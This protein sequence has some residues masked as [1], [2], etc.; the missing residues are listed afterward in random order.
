M[1]STST[2]Q[3]LIAAFYNCPCDSV[4]ACWNPNVPIR[5]GLK[6]GSE[7]TGAVG[8]PGRI[9][10]ASVTVTPAEMGAISPLP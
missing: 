3:V 2:N 4:L 10:T 9:G 5:H 8:L 1:P 7:S 6:A